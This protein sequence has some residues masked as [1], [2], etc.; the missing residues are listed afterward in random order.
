MDKEEAYDCLFELGERV[1]KTY[2]PCD[3]KNGTC[4]SVR[5]NGIADCGCCK[6]CE[7]LSDKGCTVK[8]LSCKLWLCE[9]LRERF[10]KVERQFSKLK[11][12]AQEF[13]FQMTERMTKEKQ[14]EWA[15]QLEKEGLL[16]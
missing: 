13:G 5:E 3:W 11:R 7:Y 6:G 8:S 1:L 15:A 9:E 4:R 14:L 10:P 16:S 2:N 12:V